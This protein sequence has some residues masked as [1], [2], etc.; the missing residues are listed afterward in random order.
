MFIQFT[1]YD[2]RRAAIQAYEL[3]W[4]SEIHIDQTE[5]APAAD[6]VRIHTKGG[7]MFDCL[8][9]FDDISA[10]LKAAYDAGFTEL[11]VHENGTAFE[12]PYGP[13]KGAVH[14]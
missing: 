6:L 2:G 4:V 3:D 1:K 11:V 8:D 13:A 10:A 14:G 9:S 5:T 12:V 7:E